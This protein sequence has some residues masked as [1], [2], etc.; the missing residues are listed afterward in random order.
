[1]VVS[2]PLYTPVTF[3]PG[4]NLG[5]YWT[6]GWVGQSEHTREETNVL[7]LPQFKSW[8]VQAMTQS[9]YWLPLIQAESGTSTLSCWL[10]K[11]GN[12]Y[13]NDMFL[14]SVP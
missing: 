6:K 11:Y 7:S 12:N 5:T 10:N 3:P 14:K 4:K 13:Y 1:M 8:I 9:L 2:D